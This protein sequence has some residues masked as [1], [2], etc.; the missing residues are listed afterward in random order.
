MPYAIIDS[1]GTVQGLAPDVDAAVQAASQYSSIVQVENGPQVTGLGDLGALNLNQP[2][3]ALKMCGIK[4][5]SLP[6]DSTMTLGQAWELLFPFFPKT[7]FVQSKKIDGKRVFYDK[8]IVVPVGAYGSPEKMSDGLLGQNYKTAKK[9]I[10]IEV[11]TDVQGLSLLPAQS[12]KGKPGFER[13]AKINACVGASA[14]CISSCLVYSGHNMIDPYNS[15]VKAA[16]FQAFAHQPVAFMRMLS[17]NIA[18]HGR[19]RVAEPYVRLNVFSDLPWELICPDLFAHH[20]SV[21][22]YDYT[23][24]VNRVTPANYD[25]TFSFS[26]ENKAQVAYELGRERRIAVVF[27]PPYRVPAEGRARGEGLPE[28][29]DTDE[30]FGTQFGEPLEVVD[31]DV[32]DVRPR[33]PGRTIVGLRWKIPMGRQAEAFAQAQEAAFAVPVEDFD[34]ILIAATSARNEP[35]ADHDAEDEAE[36]N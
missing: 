20:A 15:I 4:P 35:I 24:V 33:D 29:L 1:D 14:A 16:R 36:E 25:L 11:A 30:L 17:E 9:D 19:K 28:M 34:G 23:K 12:L 6:T 2:A 21:R 8:P 32:S 31:G 18:R 10:G 26:G 27:I 22:F 7:R 3:H 5:L 13:F